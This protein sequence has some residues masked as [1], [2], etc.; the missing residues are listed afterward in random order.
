M[1]VGKLQFSD[2]SSRSYFLDSIVSPIP[3]LARIVGTDNGTRERA[4]LSKDTKESVS[5]SE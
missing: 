3:I 1:E 4:S 5:W 2:L